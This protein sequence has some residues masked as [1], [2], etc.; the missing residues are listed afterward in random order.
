LVARR[1]YGSARRMRRVGWRRT[2]PLAAGGTSYDE[3][4]KLQTL[5]ELF[6]KRRK[7]RIRKA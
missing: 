3:K 6:A 1:D 2:H 5:T 7:V 4:G